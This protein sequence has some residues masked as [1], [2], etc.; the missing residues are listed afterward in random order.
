MS[1]VA[2]FIAIDFIAILCLVI[3]TAISLLILFITAQKFKQ[4]HTIAYL[5]LGNSCLCT[6]E[7]CLSYLV[8]YGFILSND[9]KSV[10]NIDVIIPITSD[11]KYLCPMRSY[12]LFSGFSLLY[13]SYCLQAYYRLRQVIFYKHRCSYRKFV[14]MIFIQWFFSFLLVLPMYLTN[15]FVYIPTEFFCPIP[16]T[17]PLSVAYIAVT[18]YGVFLIIFITIYLW[19]YMYVSRTTSITIQRRRIIDRQFIMLKRIILPT[20]TLMF[21][22]IVYLFLFFQTIANH[23]RT[24]YLTYRLSYLFIAVGMS[25]IH[26]ITVYSTPPIKTSVLALIKQPLVLFRTIDHD[27][28]IN[29]MV[30]VVSPSPTAQHQQHSSQLAKIQLKAD[31][32]AN[33]SRHEVQLGKEIIPLLPVSS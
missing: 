32:I 10:F 25:F 5:L 8:I 14:L 29:S 21:L 16:F 31:A 27:N 19:I 12:F 9:I 15:A 4:L 13:T 7:L 20:F 1:A 33:P 18:V 2:L 28:T 11:Q 22:G 23:Y 6:L 24:H 3:G 17:R 30:V 26:L